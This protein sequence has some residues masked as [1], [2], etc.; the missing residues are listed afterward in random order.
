M[1]SGTRGEESN[2]S[3]WCHQELVFSRTV[4]I[5]VQSVTATLTGRLSTGMQQQKLSASRHL[6]APGP[7]GIRWP[8]LSV[9]TD[10]PKVTSAAF[11]LFLI[12]FKPNSKPL[13]GASSDQTEFKAVGRCLV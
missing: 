7:T 6:L 8:T 11:L 5:H 9:D 4:S 12:Q 3:E 2:R 13:V 10:N 1:G